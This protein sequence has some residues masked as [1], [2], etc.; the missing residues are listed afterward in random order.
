MLS[1]DGVQTWGVYKD[2]LFHYSKMTNTKTLDIAGLVTGTLAAIFATITIIMLG[3]HM[4]AAN[5]PGSNLN[6]AKYTTDGTYQDADL[7][8]QHVAV[9]NGYIVDATPG[10]NNFVHGVAGRASTQNENVC[11][12][13]TETPADNV[14]TLD[15]TPLTDWTGWIV[16]PDCERSETDPAMCAIFGAYSGLSYCGQITFA[17][18]AIQTILFTA[19]SCI[20]LKDQATKAVQ[21]SLGLQTVSVRALLKSSD[22]TTKITLGLT[23]TWGIITTCLFIAS[24]F[25]FQSFCDKI[26]TGLGRKVKYESGS[27]VACATTGCVS[28]YW[29]LFTLFVFSFLFFGI[30]NLLIS[31]GF[32][33]VARRPETETPAKSEL[34]SFM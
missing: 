16:A 22:N 15:K 14:P 11:V 32:L 8:G 1:S 20:A 29:T 2:F 19:H 27:V 18:L 6:L 13:N 17:L 26:D 9:L 5:F 30:P 34:K 24:M 28:D 31:F 25:A 4:D 3:A 12:D 23:I 7:D 10:C 21:K 33:D